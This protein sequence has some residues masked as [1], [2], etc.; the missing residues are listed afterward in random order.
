MEI[1]RLQATDTERA[2]AAVLAAQ[3]AE[4][5]GGGTPGTAQLSSLLADDRNYFIAA[6]DDGEPVGYLVA[7]AFPCADRDALAVYLYDIYVAE[8]RRNRGVGT[9]MAALLKSLCSGPGFHEIWAGT[10]EDNAPAR[11]LFERMG[12]REVPERY[13][14]YV[15]R[16][17]R[18]KS[19]S[20]M[21]DRSNTD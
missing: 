7:H 8:N 12:A 19:S 1:K 4:E 18:G 11:R 14:E 13:V 17:A 3:P 10:S 21:T 20:A 9:Q 5:R 15:Y 16:P 6:L 2:L